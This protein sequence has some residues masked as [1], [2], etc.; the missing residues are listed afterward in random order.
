MKTGDR[1]RYT[2]RFAAALMSKRRHGKQVDWR[3][4]V[5][6]VAVDARRSYVS[7]NV[8][9]VWDGTKAARAETR[10]SLEIADDQAKS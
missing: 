5:G 10:S 4:R 7:A 8:M 1:V 6:T 9:V 3:K 2:A